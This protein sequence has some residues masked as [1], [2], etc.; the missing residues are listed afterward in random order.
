MVVRPCSYQS[1]TS[2]ASLSAVR[3]RPGSRGVVRSC[4]SQR[5]SHFTLD[6][7]HLGALVLVVIVATGRT[8]Q[9][10]ARVRSGQAPA[11]PSASARSVRRSPGSSVTPRVRLPGTFP[12]LVVLRSQ[13]RL[14]LDGRARIL[15]GPSPDLN[16]ARAL[17]PTLT[18]PR[19]GWHDHG[20]LEACPAIL[21]NCKADLR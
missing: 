21:R 16:P 19:T 11:W 9:G 6:A 1:V 13:S 5:G 20:L 7:W 3:A 15:S 10:M 14:G 4:G 17:A 18:L 12:V 2:G 8:V